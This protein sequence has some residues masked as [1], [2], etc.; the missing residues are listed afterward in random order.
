[1]ITDTEKFQGVVLRQLVVALPNGAHIRPVNHLGRV[2]A[3]A[4]G[5]LAFLI[6]FSSLRVSPW[7][8]TYTSDTF[9]E[10]RQLSAGYSDVWVFHCCGPDGIFGL[11]SGELREVL[12]DLDNDATRWV[13]ASRSRSSMY[14]IAG[15]AGRLS[16]AKAM[17]VAAF[18][19]LLREPASVPQ[20]P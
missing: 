15:S 16:R 3:F 13:S 19:A 2:D 1:M 10:I 12:G 18:C 17:G 9:E 20:M 4:F 6:K 7:R 11:D 14:R 8:F 5:N